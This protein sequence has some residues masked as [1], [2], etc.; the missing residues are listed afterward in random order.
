MYALIGNRVG[1]LKGGLEILISLGFREGDGGILT[2]PLNTNQ[3]DLA[4]RK[5]ELEVGLDILKKR[6]A[7][8]NTADLKN[9]GVIP[10][11]KPV[12]DSAPQKTNQPSEAIRFI[13]NLNYSCFLS[14]ML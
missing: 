7:L 5:L 9:S 1:R 14:L 10:I 12:D 3:Y 13:Y 2:L 8:D 6:I 4:A 11:N